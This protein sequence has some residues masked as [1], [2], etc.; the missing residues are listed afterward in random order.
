M[1]S[2][3]PDGSCPV[4][5]LYLKVLLVLDYVLASITTYSILTP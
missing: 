3:K 4:T 1:K 5:L 2:F